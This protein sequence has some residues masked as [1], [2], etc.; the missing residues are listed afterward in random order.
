MVSSRVKPESRHDESG[1]R[2]GRAIVDGVLCT[3]SGG[4]RP[5]TSVAVVKGIISGLSVEGLVNLVGE[6]TSSTSVATDQAAGGSAVRLAA[7]GAQLGNVGRRR[8]TTDAED[9]RFPLLTLSSKILVLGGLSRDTARKVDVL[10]N[11]IVLGDSHIDL[12]VAGGNLVGLLL[13]LEHLLLEG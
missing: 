10:E 9:R 3:K 11:G 5:K 8:G 2:L 4:S 12:G 6:L 13:A 7:D 1:I